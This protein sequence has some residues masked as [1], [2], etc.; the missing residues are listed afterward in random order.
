RDPW[1][2]ERRHDRSHITPRI[3]NSGGERA[4]FSRMPFGYRLDR[5]RKIP[6]LT[7]AQ[8]EPHGTEAQHRTHERVRHRRDAPHDNGERKPFPDSEA[9]DDPA[10]HQKADRVRNLER[11]YDVAVIDLAPMELLL[12]SRL[13]NTDDLPVDVVDRCCK[14]QE[15]ANDPSIMTGS[16]L[17]DS[18]RDRCRNRRHRFHKVSVSI[19]PY[20]ISKLEQPMKTTAVRVSFGVLFLATVVVF[21]QKAT[22]SVVRITADQLKW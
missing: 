4:F 11:E 1:D 10:H 3:E 2:R 12:E 8:R 15:P 9:I 14:K 20:A 5:R 21:G 22:Q 16:L 18:S 19:P 17:L 6:R 7:E 13:Q